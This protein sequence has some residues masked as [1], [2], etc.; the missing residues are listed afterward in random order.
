MD[1]GDGQSDAAEEGESVF[2][3]AGRDAAPLLEAEVAAFDGVAFGVGGLVES[4]WSTAFGT[5]RGPTTEVF[6]S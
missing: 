2:V 5:F 1:Q 4:G 3:V 6:L